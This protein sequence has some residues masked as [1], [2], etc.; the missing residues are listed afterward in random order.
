MGVN[1]KKQVSKIKIAHWLKVILKSGKLTIRKALNNVTD[2]N[3]MWAL[4]K[5]NGNPSCNIFSWN[6][7]KTPVTYK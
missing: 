5:L 1:L 3:V 7:I 2:G 4:G 6:I